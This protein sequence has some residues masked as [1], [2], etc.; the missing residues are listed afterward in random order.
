MSGVGDE[1]VRAV[2][3]AEVVVFPGGRHRDGKRPP[4]GPPKDADDLNRRLA[5]FARTDLG[6]AERFEE[7]FKGQLLRCRSLGWLA[8]DGKR[9]SQQL[10]PD[11]VEQAER[12]TVRAIQDEAEAIEGTSSDYE[13]EDA[14][15]NRVLLSA[16]LRK[17]AR[18]SESK[19]RVRAISELAACRMSAEVWEFDRDPM[20]FNVENGTLVF[21]PCENGDCVKLLPH[22][23]AD[24]ITKLASVLYDPEATCAQ[25]DTFLEHVQPDEAVR[26]FLA[27]WCGY[28]LTGDTAEQKLTFHY[29]RGRNGKGVWIDALR[30]VAG[31]YGGSIPIESF[32]DSGRARA[33]GQATPDLA[34]LPGVRCLTTVEPEKNSKLAEGLIK[35]IT[36]GDEMKARHLNRDYFA[37]MPQLKLTI[38]G[39]YRPAVKGTD[40]GIWNRLVLVPWGVYIPPEARDLHLSKKLMAEKSGILNRF[41]SGLKDWFENGLILPQSVLDA[42]AQYREDSDPLGRFLRACTAS[43]VGERVVSTDMHRVYC[44]WAKA[45]GERAWTPQG[46]GKAMRERGVPS[47]KNSVVYWL[48]IRLTKNATDF[49]NQHAD[50]APPI[51]EE[52]YGADYATDYDAD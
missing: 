36:G 27:Q 41:L 4:G 44:A 8:W 30:R 23:P 28:S 10:G 12:E 19:P 6:N 7:R 37:F 15:G 24:L 21:G 18:A 25:F 29:G 34:N 11:R 32:L 1:V 31:D 3:S 49:D 39:N 2:E 33:G 16:A 52:R 13:I 35:Q 5:G 9:W 50:A 42:T 17:H 20:R 14:K 51:D 26:R 38:A 46:F 48:D 45:N 47:L 43:S 40:E 22:D